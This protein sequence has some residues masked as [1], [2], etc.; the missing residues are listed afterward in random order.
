M[1]LIIWGGCSKR[2]KL[3]LENPRFLKDESLIMKVRLKIAI[4]AVKFIDFG[5]ETNWPKGYF[6]AT[7]AL[8]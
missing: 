5:P 7:D 2:N 8:V 1:V 3:I 4:F 6:T